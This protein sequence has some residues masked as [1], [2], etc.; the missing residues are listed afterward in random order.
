MLS[1]SSATVTIQACHAEE[2]FSLAPTART[3]CDEASPTLEGTLRSAQSDK[4][5]YS[6]LAE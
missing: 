3:V 4:S 5:V 2:R 6:A 1:I